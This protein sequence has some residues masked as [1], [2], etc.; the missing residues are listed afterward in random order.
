MLAPSANILAAFGK[1]KKDWPEY[2]PASLDLMKKRETEMQ[3]DPTIIQG[4]GLLCSEATPHN[5]HCRLVVDYLQQHWGD[6]SFQHL[7]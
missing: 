6:L 3:I 4:G 1:L 2:E 7:G 5:C